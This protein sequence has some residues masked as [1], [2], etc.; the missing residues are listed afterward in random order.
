MSSPSRNCTNDCA[1][2]AI[3]SDF[4]NASMASPVST[5]VSRQLG[6]L[7]F[8]SAKNS[9]N[10]LRRGKAL[11]QAAQLMLYWRANAGIASA[12]PGS[13]EESTPSSDAMRRAGRSLRMMRG[14]CMAGKCRR[15]LAPARRAMTQRNAFS[16]SPAFRLTLVRSSE[17]EVLVL[18]GRFGNAALAKLFAHHL[19]QAFRSAETHLHRGGAR[20]GSELR[21]PGAKLRSSR[22]G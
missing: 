7:K 10:S 14:P 19:Q 12:V 11:W 1:R 20:R 15:N 4:G 22:T 5:V 16:F 18:Q 13:R 9:P 8:W 3:G 6:S 21:Q 17:V 2:T